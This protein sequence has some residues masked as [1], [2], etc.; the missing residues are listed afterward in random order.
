MTAHD[1]QVL[2]Q[3]DP[4]AQAYLTS[5]V[6]AAGPDLAH[7]QERVAQRLP[8]TKAIALDVGCG[9]GHLSFALAPHVAKLIAADP[10]PSMLATVNASAAQRGLANIQTCQA[11]ADALPFPDATFCLVSS[12]Y[13]AHH[14]PDVPAALAQMRRVA[15]PGGWLLMIDLLGG[16]TPLADTHLQAMELLRDT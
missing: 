5:A 7:A 10:A 2:Q 14:W 8:A 3:F 1:Q 11:H 4:Q 9:A 16:V 15:K 6:H 13:S 12:R